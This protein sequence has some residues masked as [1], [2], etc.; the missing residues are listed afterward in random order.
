[1]H[2]DPDAT[3]AR[4]TRRSAS[5]TAWRRMLLAGFIIQLLLILFVTAIGLQQL[6]VTTQNLNQVVD[7]HMRKQNFT[8]A[9]VVSARERT[10]IMLS[11][12][13]I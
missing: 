3:P 11:L 2:D 9:M 7:V 1:M 10:L 5:P 8:K 13:H 12:I 6:G 4:S